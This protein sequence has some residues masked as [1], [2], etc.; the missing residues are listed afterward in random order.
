LKSSG[1][2]PR[3]RRHDPEQKDFES[4]GIYRLR[5]GKVIQ[6]WGMNDSARLMMQLGALPA[7]GK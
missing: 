6:H 1:E 4:W 5:D 7:P 2:G 3:C